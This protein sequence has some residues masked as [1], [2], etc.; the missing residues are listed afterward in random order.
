M[1]CSQ[2]GEACQ[3]VDAYGDGIAMHGQ[4][5]ASA[6]ATSTREEAQGSAGETET[7]GRCDR[8]GRRWRSSS[9]EET[10]GGQREKRKA[11]GQG[12]ETEEKKR[13]EGQT[14]LKHDI[15][16]FCQLLSPPSGDDAFARPESLK[17]AQRAMINPSEPC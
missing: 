8:G 11:Q 14:A 10:K 9:E 16:A 12:G 5:D 4:S 1:G 3:A 17:A 15:F 6:G 7:G 2:E 13:L